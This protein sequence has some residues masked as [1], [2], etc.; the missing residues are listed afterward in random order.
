MEASEEFREEQRALA[1]QQDVEFL[2]QLKAEGMQVN[3]LTAE[4]RD[5][6]RQAA[7]SVYDKYESQIGKDLIDRALAANE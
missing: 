5:E 3:E 4:Q 7:Q 2:E 1:Q 6:F